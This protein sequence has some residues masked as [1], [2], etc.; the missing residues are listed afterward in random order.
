MTATNVTGSF[1]GKVAFVTGAASGIGRGTALAFPRE[2][3]SVVVADISDQ[4]NQ[5]TARRIE[6][7]GGQALAVRCD[8]TQ[9]EDVKSAVGQAVDAF[10]RLDVAFNNAGAEQKPGPRPRSPRR[11]GTGSSPSTC[12]ACSSA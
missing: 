6:E 2:G 7:L 3:A 10:G 11:N 5:E 8:V 9:D 12:A 1:V 4:G